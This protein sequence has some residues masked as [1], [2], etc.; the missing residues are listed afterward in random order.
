MIPHR[1]LTAAV[2]VDTGSL[3]GWIWVGV[4]V[5]G[6]LAVIVVGIRFLRGGPKR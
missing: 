2:T 1:A 5:I 4:A 6:L 3:P